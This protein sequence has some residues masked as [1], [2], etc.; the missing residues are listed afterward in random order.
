MSKE[1]GNEMEQ[2]SVN[3]TLKAGKLPPRQILADSV[4]ETVKGL[5]MDQSIKPESR[6]NI[7]KLARE[8]QVSPT[9]V[10]EALARLESEGLVT[11]EPLRGYSAASLLDLSTFLQLFEI[12]LLLEPVVARKAATALREA[13]LLALEQL[14]LAMREVQVGQTYQEYRQIAIADAMFHDILA[15]ACGNV[16]FQETLE[17]L[18]AHLHLYRL[19]FYAGIATDTIIEHRAILDALRQ[20]DTEAA[21]TAMAW[22]LEQ[23]QR[24]LLRGLETRQNHT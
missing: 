13:D 2:A 22:H 17:R 1:Q 23:A 24:R 9:P 4:Y 7:D 3:D 19:Y 5:L 15:Q 18:H 21:A 8:L 14:V 6:I 12:R 16:F 10:R 20:R 11:K